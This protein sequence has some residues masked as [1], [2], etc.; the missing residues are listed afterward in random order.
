MG[1]GKHFMT[2]FPQRL[3]T[4]VIT[5]RPLKYFVRYRSRIRLESIAAQSARVP[6]QSK[7]MDVVFSKCHLWFLVIGSKSSVQGTT[8]FLSSC[9]RH[10]I[11]PPIKRR[12]VRFYNCAWLAVQEQNSLFLPAEIQNTG[13]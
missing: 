5:L 11:S 8:I 7:I 12:N 9:A 10:F 6:P 1:V 13:W 4:P 2:V 3:S